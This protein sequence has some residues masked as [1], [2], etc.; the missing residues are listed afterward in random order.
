VL[1]IQDPLGL[2][3]QVV[4]V[5]QQIEQLICPGQDGGRQ[6]FEQIKEGSFSL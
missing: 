3:I 5:L 4:I 6:L 2:P 1:Y